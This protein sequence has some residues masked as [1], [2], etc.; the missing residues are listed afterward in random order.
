MRILDQTNLQIDLAKLGFHP[1]ALAR[2]LNAIESP[3]GMVLVTG[4]TGSGKSTTLYSALA[5]DQQDPLQHHDGEDPVEYNIAGIN[6]V[7]VH[8]DIGLHLRRGA[9]QPS[10]ARTPTSSWSVRFETSTPRRI[11]IKAALTG[12][13]VLEHPAHQRRGR[14]PST[15]LSTWASSPSW[16]PA[17]CCSSSPSGSCAACARNASVPTTLHP[18]VLRELGILENPDELRHLRAEGV[19]GVQ[20]HR[21]QGPRW[22]VRGHG[23]QRRHCAR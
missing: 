3:Y 19:P 16:C 14:V 2:F 7:K 23:D 22:P 11:A 17:P 21:L 5:E 15:D 18:E 9:A 13:L 12:H 1:A 6:Q 20:R 4:P 10:S 8:E